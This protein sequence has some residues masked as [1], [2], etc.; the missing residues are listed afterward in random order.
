[1]Q[2]SI[3]RTKIQNHIPYKDIYNFYKT[4][5]LEANVPG[6]NFDYLKDNLGKRS[7]DNSTSQIDTETSMD[8]NKYKIRSNGHDNFI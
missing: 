2:S 1:M 5:Q 8:A 3:I 6:V 7:F 4:S